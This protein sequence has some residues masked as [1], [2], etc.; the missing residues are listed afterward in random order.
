M[1]VAMLSF[2]A[3]WDATS[4]QVVVAYSL[5]SCAPHLKRRKT[6]KSRFYIYIYFFLNFYF[7]FLL[8]VKRVHVIQKQDDTVY[9][10]D[11]LLCHGIM[12]MQLLLREKYLWQC[13]IEENHSALAQMSIPIIRQCCDNVL[14]IQCILAVLCFTAFFNKMGRKGWE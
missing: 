10:P 14:V 12:G 8:L 13:I 11:S 9:V 1:L 2:P 5:H 4:E 6:K 3:A 7:Y